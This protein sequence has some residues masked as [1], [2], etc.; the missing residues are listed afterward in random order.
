MASPAL[1]ASIIIVCILCCTTASA[2]GS[3]PIAHD[4]NQPSSTGGFTTAG[5]DSTVGLTAESGPIS[6][7]GV[8]LQHA[9]SPNTLTIISTGS[10]RVHYS[11]TTSGSIASGERA[12]LVDADQPDNVTNRTA[13]GS[14][15]QRGIDDFTFSGRITALTLRGGPARVLINGNEVN[16]AAIPATTSFATNTTASLTIPT[17]ARETVSYQQVSLDV[18]GALTL[19]VEG[20]RGRFQRLTLDERFS[21]TDSTIARRAQLRATATRIEIRIARLQEREA[22]AITAY[23]NGSIS[24][25]EFLHE[26]A[27]IDTM[28]DQLAVAADRVAAR[29]DSVP[30]SS[31]NGQPA[32]NWAQNRRIELGPLQGPV[33]EQIANT[34]R[35]NN[36][37]RTEGNPPSGVIDIGPAHGQRLEPLRVYVETSREGIALTTVYNDQYYRE[38][39]LSSARNA[40]G[41][42]LSGSVDA[43]DRVRELY[44]WASANSG[45]TELS[46][47]RRTNVSRV[48]LFHNQGQ[49]TTFLNQS[50]GQVVA[51]HQ[52]KT[53]STIPTTNPVT[54]TRGSLRLRVNRTHSTGPLEVSLTTPAGDPV[55]GRVAINGRTVGQ[56]GADGRLW[57]VAP[58]NMA[59]IDVRANG[60][61]IRIR[62][63][64]RPQSN[65]SA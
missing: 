42:G 36:T 40:T 49:L 35:G 52:Q 24:A 63:P 51:E 44:P 31:I 15:A 57:T 34:L 2:L 59:T 60:E 56:T 27:H 7:E 58:Y 26:L 12:D 5:G 28:A 3:V 21:V 22:M 50:S 25:Q 29:A 54:A 8:P 46:G 53:L 37:V 39:S 38:A 11:A 45:Y 18:S 43:F 33:R 61:R 20:L 55:D 19:D 48:T 13:S 62:I 9:K 14:T 4:E 6:T 1:R 30:R 41:G 23:N 64:S 32:V 16:P 47:D 17:N 65:R 10:E